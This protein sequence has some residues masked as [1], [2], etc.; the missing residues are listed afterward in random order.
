MRFMYLGDGTVEMFGH[1]FRA[2][3]PVDV[4]DA[5]AIRKLFHNQFFASD[6]VLGPQGESGHPG[7]IGVAEAP[8]RRGRPLKVTNA[9]D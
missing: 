9:E 6:E 2:G 8:K 7:P 5:H 4:T 1:T 3:E